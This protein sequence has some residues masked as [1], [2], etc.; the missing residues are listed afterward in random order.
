MMKKITVLALSATLMATAVF[1]GNESKNILKNGSFEIVNNKG[2]LSY[3]VPADWNSKDKRGKTT[4]KQV[5][6]ATKGKKAAKIDSTVG[7]GNILI[8]QHFKKEL[9]VEKQYKVT[10]KFKGP[11]GGYVYTSFY[12]K[13]SQ[14]K[15]LKPKY[16]HSQKMKCGNEWQELTAAYTV[17]PEFNK[18][19]IYVRCTKTPVIIDNVKVVE[20]TK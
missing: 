11:E 19:R 4:I 8:I 15:K 5:D 3:W 14:D 16:E 13:S 2:Q 20:V 1:A 10:L 9:G 7:K 17:K 6:D 12:A 18:L